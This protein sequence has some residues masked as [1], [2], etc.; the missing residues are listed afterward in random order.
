MS[1]TP[2][3]GSIQVDFAGTQQEAEE[4]VKSKAYLFPSGLTAPTNVAKK[5]LGEVPVLRAKIIRVGQVKT[6]V[7]NFISLGWDVE[8]QWVIMY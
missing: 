3:V 5:Y 2:R 1:H 6:V 4:Y 8:S 7:K